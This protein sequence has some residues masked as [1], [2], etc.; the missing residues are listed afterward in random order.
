MVRNRAAPTAASA[1]AAVLIASFAM[2]PPTAHSQADELTRRYQTESIVGWRAPASAA[3]P[4]KVRLLTINDFHGHLQT[5]AQAEGA[6]GP[7]PMG[8]A[9]VLAAYVD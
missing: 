4:V 8:G 6:G 7:R 5:R 9:A 2:L 3:D 1:A